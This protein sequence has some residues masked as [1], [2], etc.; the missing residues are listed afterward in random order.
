MQSQFNERGFVG[1]I[2]CDLNGG[3]NY[4]CRGASFASVRSYLYHADTTKGIVDLRVDRGGEQLKVCRKV[5]DTKSHD[6]SR[7]IRSS[8]SSHTAG[9]DESDDDGRKKETHFEIH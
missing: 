7:E 3:E 4:C 5:S 9:G 2:S 8:L 1:R 6:R